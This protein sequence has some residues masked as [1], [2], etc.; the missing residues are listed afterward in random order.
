[1]DKIRAGFSALSLTIIGR[2][3]CTTAYDLASNMVAG[4]RLG[5]SACRLDY[6]DSKIYQ[7]IFKIKFLAFLGHSLFL[8]Q[9]SN[10]PSGGMV[11]RTLSI[12]VPKLD[13]LKD[14]G[15][16]NPRLYPGPFLSACSVDVSENY[17]PAL[18]E[19][20]PVQRVEGRSKDYRDSAHKNVRMHNPLCITLKGSRPG[21][22]RTS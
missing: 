18:Q 9:Y 16:K 8:V 10:R 19:I 11:S 21:K 2:W 4:F 15:T 1:M 22:G 7:T 20:F 13:G 14:K 6:S 3:R 12:C 5:Q 17:C